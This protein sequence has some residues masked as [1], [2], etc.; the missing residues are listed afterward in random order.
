M[1]YKKDVYELG[2][3]P[4]LY[5]EDKYLSQLPADIQWRHQKFEPTFTDVK[6]DWTWE[7]EWRIIGDFNLDGVYFEAIVPSYSYAKRLID[8]L[9]EEEIQLYEDCTNSK[10]ET[11][12][13][14]DFCDPASEELIQDP[15]PPPEEFDKTIICLD[16]TC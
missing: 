8:E 4:V 10:V 12:N 1:V 11:M 16:G 6:Y 9:N 15:C 13:F 3:R 7:R 2:G 5:L 14:N